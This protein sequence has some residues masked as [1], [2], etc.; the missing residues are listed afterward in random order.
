[1]PQR[2]RKLKYRQ[3]SQESLAIAFES[4]KSG[5]LNLNDA[6]AKYKIPE[7][8][9]RHRL[10]GKVSQDCTNSGPPP[11]MSAEEEKIFVNHVGVMAKLGYEY[12]RSEIVSLASQYAVHLGVRDDE[13]PLSMKWFYNL[14]ARWP[15]VPT[16]GTLRSMSIL[17]SKAIKS[18]IIASYFYTL[19]SIITE[20]SL[21]DKPQYIYN[22]DEKTLDDCKM[23]TV[24]VSKR[25]AV[26]PG[27]D[28]SSSTVTLISC[29]NA[30]GTQIPPYF[31]FPGEL[32]NPEN[33]FGGSVGTAGEVTENGAT[34]TQLFQSYI[35]N[36]FL[37]NIPAGRPSDQ[38]IL[39]LYDGFR[40]HISLPLI[41]WAKSRNIIL[42]VLPL[43]MTHAI[44]PK[45]DACMGPL[46]DLYNAECQRY[47]RKQ[48]CASINRNKVCS[49]AC[50][51]YADALSPQSLVSGFKNS[52]INPLDHQIIT[53]MANQNCEGIRRRRVRK[54]PT[55]RKS[56]RAISVKLSPAKKGKKNTK[57]S[58]VD[59]DEESVTEDET[60][61]EEE[62][63]SS[64]EQEEKYS[65]YIS[66]P[67][68]QSTASNESVTVMAVVQDLTLSIQGETVIAPQ[69]V[70]V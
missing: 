50:K 1:M 37:K 21:Q 52:G 67:E 61:S 60:T 63:L 69:D 8:T 47:M 10:N 64:D 35:E 9:L 26:L 27:V 7:A 44:E 13:K 49:V 18:S 42:F 36:H 54:T 23:S 28:L 70:G 66:D 53:D 31:V 5:Q 14:K 17:K 45:T 43:H 4:V 40:S 38:Y 15:N 58:Q 29:G 19:E 65:I 6:C 22:V 46:R 20:H 34:D 3:Y 48:D 2:A 16:L 12:R 68:R 62:I 33:L 25:G 30:D 51:A 11:L 24:T 41:E 56:S 59:L 55:K 32:M 39:M 57:S